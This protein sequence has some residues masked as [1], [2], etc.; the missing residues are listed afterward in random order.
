MDHDALADVCATGSLSAVLDVTD[1]EPLP[2]DHPLRSLP[3]VLLTPPTS[4]GHADVNAGFW[5]SSRPA[6][7]S[8]S[9]PVCQSSTLCGSRTLP[10]RHDAEAVPGRYVTL[11]GRGRPPRRR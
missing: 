9:S 7:P 1:P 11:G 10:A 6:R 8:G 3:N 2:A 4:P 5:A